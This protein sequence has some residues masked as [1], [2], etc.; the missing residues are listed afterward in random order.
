MEKMGDGANESE[1]GGYE[2]DEKTEELENN[3]EKL[4]K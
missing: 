3:D 4:S 2:G 1:E